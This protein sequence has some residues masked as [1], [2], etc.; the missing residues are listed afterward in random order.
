M[1]IDYKNYADN[2][3][4]EIRPSILQRAKNKCEFC[5][6]PNAITIIRGTWG[7]VPAW[8]DESGSIHDAETGR[9]IDED[10]IGAVD[11]RG[12]CRPFQ[13]VLTIM[14]LNHD[15]T[16]NRPENLKAG[17]QKCHNNY[18]AANRKKN[19]AKKKNQLNLFTT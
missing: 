11:P 18:D 1:P 13:V 14:H 6:V 9:K 12:H 15:T 19:R 3:H 7:G 4:T 10:Y 2:W 5:N 16:D 17:C 8:Q